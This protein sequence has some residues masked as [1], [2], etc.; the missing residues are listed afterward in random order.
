MGVIEKKITVEREREFN[1][2]KHVKEHNC[3]RKLNQFKE[4]KNNKQK[5]L[6]RKMTRLLFKR[7]GCA[8]FPHVQGSLADQHNQPSQEVAALLLSATVATMPS[9]RRYG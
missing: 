8:G 7:T 3:G 5:I 6:L 2:T 1:R 9:E 4:P